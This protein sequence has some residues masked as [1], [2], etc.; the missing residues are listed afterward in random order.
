VWSIRAATV[1]RQVRIVAVVGNPKPNSRTLGVAKAVAESLVAA[2]AESECQVVDLAEYAGELFD[3]SSSALSE[4]SDQVAASDVLVVASPTFKATY[5][6]LLK[7]F[8][9]RYG[10][11]PLVGV[12]GLPVM[13]GAGSQHALAV[14][15][16]LRPLLI[17]LGATVPTSGLYVTEDEFGDLGPVVERWSAVAS[18]IVSRLVTPGSA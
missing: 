7:A 9:D 6:G 4:I 1:S 15:V 2:I 14:E 8:F 11:R 5:T 3:Q 18:P 17:E 12:L 13:T 10:H 16:F